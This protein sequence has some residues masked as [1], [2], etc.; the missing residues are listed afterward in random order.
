M[1]MKNYNYFLAITISILTVK[2]GLA[3]VNFNTKQVTIVDLAMDRKN[4]ATKE[5][6]QL[7]IFNGRGKVYPRRYTLTGFSGFEFEHVVNNYRFNFDFVDKKSGIVIKDNVHE[8]M[9]AQDPLGWNFRPGSPYVTV[10]QHETWFPHYYEKTGTFHKNING[11]WVSF[12]IETRTYVSNKKDEVLMSI[13]L[14]NRSDT[15]LELILK[16]FQIGKEAFV[17]D[18]ENA[19]MTLSSDLSERTENGIKWVLPPK[20]TVTKNFAIQA[21]DLNE[22]APAYFQTDINQ[23]IS[24]AIS[25][26]NRQFNSIASKFPAFRSDNKKLMNLYKR[27]IG[28]MYLSRWERED[29][30]HNPFWQVG[31]FPI[32][33]AWD[34]SFTSDALAMLN[35]NIVESIVNDVL[36]YGKMQS[37]YIGRNGEQFVQILYIQDPFALQTLIESYVRYTGDITILDRK[38]GEFTIYEWMKKWG[39]L[40][41]NKFRTSGPLINMGDANDML[42]EIRTDGYDHIVPVVNGLAIHYYKTL[43]QWSKSKKD[44]DAL[45]YEKWANEIA[46]AFHNELWNDEEGWFYNMYEDGSKDMVWSIHLFDLLNTPILTANERFKLTSHIKSGEFLGKYG[47]YSIS[48]KDEIHWDLLDCDFGGGGFYMGSPLGIAKS[49][50]AHGESQRAWEIMKRIALLPDHFPY[51]PQSPRADEPFEIKNGGNMQISSGAALEAIWYG[52]FGI[53]LHED[54]TISV[55]PNYNNE[56]GASELKGFRYRG[57]VYD[58]ILKSDV[59]EVYKDQEFITRKRYGVIANN[60]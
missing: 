27:V 33:T 43:A 37:S 11:N 32:I 19:R 59:Y 55:N 53:K 22:E 52:I 50:Y 23:R 54:G 57:H 9:D 6:E 16:P 4:I 31:W 8:T 45:K 56:I 17:V 41:N 39:D 44:T 47:M 42:I 10:P 34:F 1:K 48:P 35:P 30:I 7:W 49:L 15:K 26:A 38:A 58:V 18:T 60:I 36:N 2:T 14:K 12:G 46:N 28:T 20:S 3:Q 40:I 51:M 13:T 21:T 24:E 5:Y 25:D 29:F